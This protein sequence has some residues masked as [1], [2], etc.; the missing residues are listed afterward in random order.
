[1]SVPLG[2][3]EGHITDVSSSLP[4]ILD[5]LLDLPELVPKD[6]SGSAQTHGTVDR[7]AELTGQAHHRR[8][9]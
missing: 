1:M 6:V 3:E 8:R 9:H 2:L 4:L 7:R 5:S